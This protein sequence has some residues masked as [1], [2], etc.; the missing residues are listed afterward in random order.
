MSI[1]STPILTLKTMLS[2]CVGFQTWLGVEE[3]A[4]P[5]VAALAKIYIEGVPRP[6]GQDSFTREDY[7][8]LRPFVILYDHEGMAG[9]IE[10]EGEAGCFGTK[11]TAIIVFESPVDPAKT[12]EESWLDIADKIGKTVYDETPGQP[13]LIQMGSTPGR[14]R[15]NSIDHDFPGRTPEEELNAYGDA[16]YALLLVK[17]G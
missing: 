12:P 14:L 3:E 8:A 5:V 2:E 11:G 6:E 10:R 9:T 4:D 1:F 7:E 15:I 16:Y 13:G 17:W